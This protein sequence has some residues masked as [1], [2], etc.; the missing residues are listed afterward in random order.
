MR[1]LPNPDQPNSL[2]LTLL[3]VLF[4]YHMQVHMYK[5]TYEA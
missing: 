3:H 5:Y 4:A 1:V 2:Y